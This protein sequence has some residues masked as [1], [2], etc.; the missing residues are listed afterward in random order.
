[1]YDEEELRTSARK[2]N[3]AITFSNTAWRKTW[4]RLDVDVKQEQSGIALNI[5]TVT[6]AEYFSQQGKLLE[7][8]APS[9]EVQE[10]ARKLESRCSG[11]VPVSQDSVPSANP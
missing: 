11:A 2:V 1:M 3:P 10:A 7:Q 4:D 5:L 6:E 9:G 8:I